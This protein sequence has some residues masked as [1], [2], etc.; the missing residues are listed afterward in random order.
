MCGIAGI[1]D[2]KGRPIAA[3]LLEEMLALLRHRGPD[4]K[5]VHI[6]HDAGAG[7]SMGFAHAR[8]SIIDLSANARQ[9]LTNEDKSLWLVMNGEIYNFQGLCRALTSRGHRFSSSGDAEVILHLYEEKGEACIYELEGMFAFALWDAKKK[10]LFA[11]RDRVG[12]KPFYYTYEQ[13]KFSFGSE[14]RA[15]L[16]QND[17]NAAINRQALDYYLAYGYVPSPE[18]IF[19]HVKKIPPAHYLVCDRRGIALT[20]YWSLDYRTKIVCAREEEY[21]ERFMGLLE[22]AVRTRLVADVPLGA[23][24]SGGIDSSCVV[25]MMHKLGVPHINTFTIAFDFDDYSEARYAKLVAERFGT[26]HREFSVKPDAVELLPKLIWHYSEPF[27]DSSCLPTYYVA[28]KTREH[29]TVALNGDGGDESFLGY[30]R[31]F[32]VIFARRL[33]KTP[34]LARALLK[35]TARGAYLVSPSSKKRF[36]QKAY[37]FFSAL[38]NPRLR[39]LEDIYLAWVQIFDLP[40]RA[41]L[42]TDGFLSPE[43]LEHSDYFMK[44]LIAGAPADTIIEKLVSAD[45]NSYLPEDL[46]VKVDIATMAHALE[47]RSPFLDRHVMEFAAA[48]PMHMKLRGTTT[49]Y[50]IRKAFKDVLPPAITARK[51]MGFGVPVGQWFK[52]ELKTSLETILCGGALVRNG[53]FNRATIARLIKEHASGARNHEFRLWSLLNLELWYQMFVEKKRE[54]TVNVER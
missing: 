42:Y 39:S 32:G 9:P 50:I 33:M 43:A 13:E 54:V 28:E 19:T 3:A 26:N 8:L 40:L 4:D 5:G 18:T 1:I 47:G 27:G 46:L 38:E 41:S 2:Y 7:I 29:V 44:N 11:A 21:I 52:K 31:Y 15:L 48:L 10:K 6:D 34:R 14:I 24:L 22:E 45:I 23:F 30:E 12:K 17:F 36:F 49:K 53:Y 37:R 20:R 25:A 16:A 35:N 51:K